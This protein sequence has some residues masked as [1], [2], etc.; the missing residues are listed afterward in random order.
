VTDPNRPSFLWEFSAIDL[1]RDPNA[2]AAVQIDRILDPLTGEPKW[3]GFIVTGKMAD[4]DQ[5]TAVYLIDISDGSVIKRVRLDDD[6]DLNVDGALDANEAGY[7]RG[8][9]LNRHPVIVDSNDNG[10]V[11]RLYV[12]SSCGHV[13]KINIPDDPETPGNLTQCVLNTDFTDKDGN[14]IPME[15]RQN[16]IYATPTVVAEN[17]IGEDGNLDGRLRIVFGTGESTHENGGVD[18]PG[19]RNYII[20]Y[21]DTAANGECNP[22]KHELDWFYELEEKHQ[23]RAPIAV[24]AGQ[25]YVGTT[26]SEVEDQCVALREENGDLGLLTVIDLEGLVYMS[27]RI[28]NVHFAP[29]L[30]DQHIYLMTPTGLQSFGSGIY[31]NELLSF[32]VTIV[33]ARSWE[34]VN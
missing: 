10:F 19:T 16:A 34:E 23:V 13:Y 27:K 21:V 30:E 26:T 17:G 20:S 29:L 4:K 28:G 31:N 14:Q 25:L 11:D 3:A 9:L 5:Y 32:G 24:A 6:V 33:N 22:T 1:F 15:Q 7:G 18:I 8:G 12:G 2:Q